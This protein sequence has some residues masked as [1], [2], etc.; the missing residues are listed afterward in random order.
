MGAP[1]ASPGIACPAVGLPASACANGFVDGT[2][3]FKQTSFAN[4]D[5][6]QGIRAFIDRGGFFHVVGTSMN[7]LRPWVV[8]LTNSSGTWTKEIVAQPLGRPMDTV[9]AAHLGVDACGHPSVLFLRRFLPAGQQAFDTRAFLA[10]RANG[11]WTDA[12]IPVPTSASDATPSSHVSSADLAVE[13][14]GTLHIVAVPQ[15]FAIPVV[16][17]RTTGG[18]SFSVDRLVNGASGINLPAVVWS[19]ILGTV[20]TDAAT[21][22]RPRI[23]LKAGGA[24]TS[25]AVTGGEAMP[26]GGGAG[27]P[28]LGVHAD[29]G[30][31]V[32]VAWRSESSIYSGNNVYYTRF[33]SG[34]F[35]AP[36]VIASIAP[37]LVAYRTVENSIRVGANA[38][39]TPFVSHNAYY[40][41]QW[42]HPSAGA[43]NGWASNQLT[44][45]GEWAAGV[46]DSTGRGYLIST[47][48]AGIDVRTQSC[49]P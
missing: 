31:A 22:G 33:S 38:T 36:V 24:W 3:G 13:P 27:G 12:E 8:Y 15:D 1:D 37:S 39:G 5:D 10:T 45:S 40:G 35:A 20:V 30:G 18:N 25:Y 47:G 19:P 49:A 7:T 28:S 42:T 4:L 43:P 46:M 48:A 26:S 21:T 32:H 14:N 16:L 23:T 41:P 29:S 2:F 6:L 11:V 17:T 9:N 44:K 34:A